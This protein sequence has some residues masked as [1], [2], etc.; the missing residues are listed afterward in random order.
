MPV[1]IEALKEHLE[2]YATDKAHVQQ[3]LDSLRGALAKLQ[4]SQE[5]CDKGEDNND[6]DEDGQDGPPQDRSRRV[7]VSYLPITIGRKLTSHLSLLPLPL[8][9]QSE[10][11]GQ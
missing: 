8:L 3:Q 10:G 6:S 5:Q 1:I 11:C 9:S 2:D 4:C 7:P